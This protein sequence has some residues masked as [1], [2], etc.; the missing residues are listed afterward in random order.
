MAPTPQKPPSIENANDLQVV[1][2]RLR[3]S[4]GILVRRF[5]GPA[6]PNHSGRPD[7]PRV[8]R[9]SMTNLAR[10]S[11]AIDSEQLRSEISPR[12]ALLGP[13]N[14]EIDRRDEQLGELA[15]A[16]ERVRGLLTMPQTGA[17]TAV[18]FV[19]TL[20]DAGRFRSAHQV[21][22]TSGWCRGSGAQ[23]SYSCGGALRSRAAPGCAGCWWRRRG[24]W[25]RTR[26]RPRRRRWRMGGADRSP[27]WHASRGGRSGTEARGVELTR[28][29]GHL[30]AFARGVHDAESRTH[31]RDLPTT[32]RACAIGRPHQGRWAGVAGPRLWLRKHQW[33]LVSFVTR[34]ALRCLRYK[35][36]GSGE[37]AES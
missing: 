14:Q 1:R 12:L 26:E 35:A 27:T 13:L 32:D 19:A 10:V 9:N 22:A 34:A 31:R 7:T 2:V 17:V 16:D 36:T 4:C 30:S 18:S 6:T 21:E 28:S 15:V 3:R 37:I 24:A 25:L 11:M 33:P 23:A 29:G 8:V 5:L 20:H